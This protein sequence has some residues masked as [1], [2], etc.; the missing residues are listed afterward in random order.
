MY[1]C[2]LQ[3]QPARPTLSIRFRSPV[4]DLSTHFGRIWGS[5]IEYLG[6]LGEHPTGAPFA[7]YYNMDMQDLDIEAGF[8]VARPLP[9]KGE[10]QATEIPGGM[11]AICHYTGPYNQVGPAYGELTQFVQQQGY[12][13]SGAAYE[14]YLND[15]SAVPPQEL[16]TDVAFPVTRVE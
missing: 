7:A 1:P 6:T 12:A 2:E 5:L 4:Q 8:P 13:P 10:I 15:P 14:W 9:G 16:K 11:F 3:E